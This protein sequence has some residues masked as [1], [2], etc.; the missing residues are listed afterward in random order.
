MVMLFEAHRRP[1]LTQGWISK[2]Y[3]VKEVAP[4]VTV[5]VTGSE[6]TDFVTLIAPMKLSAPLPRFHI[7][8]IDPLS[9]GHVRV[10]RIGD[11][12][13]EIV[14]ANGSARWSR[15]STAGKSVQEEVP[16]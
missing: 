8:S 11:N 3:G 10:E 5:T 12:V 1:S 13:D 2:L 4:V 14:W 15:L 7:E 9:S 16:R 6:S